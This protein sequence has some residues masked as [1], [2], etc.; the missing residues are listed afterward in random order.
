MLIFVSSSGFVSTQ[1]SSQTLNAILLD[2]NPVTMINKLRRNQRKQQLGNVPPSTHTHA[3]RLPGTKA[4]PA[5]YI[6]PHESE[7]ASHSCCKGKIDLLDVEIDN[8]SVQHLFITPKELLSVCLYRKRARFLEIRP[9]LL[10]DC[11]M[12]EL[13][14]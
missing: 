6:R 10:A 1:E 7:L 11:R 2:P 8:L 14:L 5:F 4:N 3:V 9:L 12:T 13:L